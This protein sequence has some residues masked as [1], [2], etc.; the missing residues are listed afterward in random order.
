MS[1]T[2]SM[3]RSDSIADNLPDALRQSRYHMKKCFAKYTEKGRRIMKLHHLMDEM[4]HAVDDIIERNQLLHGELGFI[5]CSTQ[6]CF[7]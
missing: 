1:S 5:L 2:V 4:E 3:K 7:N 6:V